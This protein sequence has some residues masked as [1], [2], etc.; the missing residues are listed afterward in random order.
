MKFTHPELD[1]VFDTEDEKV[2]TLVIENPKLLFRLLEDIQNQISGFRGDAVLSEKERPLDMAKYAEVLDVFVPFSINR[3]P[4]LTK[5][6]AALEKEAASPVI[7]ERT[8]ELLQQLTDYLDALAFDFPCDI[9]FPKLSV[10]AVIKSAGAELREEYDSMP[11]KV[12]DYMELV[13]TFDRDKLYITVNM[14]AFMTD[15]EAELFLSTVLS[16]GYHML[17]LENSAKPLLKSESRVIIDE[18]LCEIDCNSS[19]F[20]LE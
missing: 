19:V 11:E 4:L 7:F 1:T 14:R 20:P 6:N 3:K 18:D 17:M 10:P 8:G 12:I 13:R 5:L 9:V 15:E 16:H 2:H